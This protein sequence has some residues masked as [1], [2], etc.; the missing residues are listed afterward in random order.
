MTSYPCHPTHWAK[1]AIALEKCQANIS[2]KSGNNGL[3]R[4]MT[5]LWH[6]TVSQDVWISW[7][8]CPIFAIV[9]SKTLAIPG[10]QAARIISRAK[11]SSDME[12]F[13]LWL[14]GFLPRNMRPMATISLWSTMGPKMASCVGVSTGY[15]YDIRAPN[16]VSQICRSRCSMVLP[17][18]M[19]T[20]MTNGARRFLAVQVQIYWRSIYNDS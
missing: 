20:K 2:I 3:M 1:I 6:L 15:I 19:I 5:R 13:V 17:M 12:L 10:S 7:N 18:K 4:Q 11:S 9:V 8:W 14:T 16:E